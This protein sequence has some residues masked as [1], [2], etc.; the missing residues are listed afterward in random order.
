MSGSKSTARTK[1]AQLGISP[2]ALTAAEAAAYCG[3]SEGTFRNRVREG[4]LPSAIPHLNRW[5]KKALDRYIDGA[6]AELVDPLLEAIR[7]AAHTA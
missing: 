2:R 3:I 4:K 7:G 5:D 6:A 1:L